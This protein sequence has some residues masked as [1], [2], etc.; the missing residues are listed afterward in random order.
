[1][2]EGDLHTL[3]G[4]A[5]SGDQAARERAFAELLRLLMIF[6]RAG[7]GSA[8]RDHRES[9][10]V[11]QSI[12]R[13]FVEDHALGKVR[14]ASEGEVIAYLK[15]IV[16]SKMA[17][18]A[19]H[20]RAGKR[21]GGAGTPVPVDAATEIPGPAEP[22]VELDERTRESLRRTLGSLGDQ[23]REL[24]RMKLAGLEWAQIAELMEK[25]AVLLRK[26]W[27]RLLTRLRDGLTEPE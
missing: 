20:D 1:M 9:D 19:R 12:A 24:V 14:F 10:D 25:D 17:E 23:E 3:L 11:C 2:A 27:S 7:M 8:I 5:S 21:G 6:V 22:E 4:R 18:L 26:Q 15:T 13:S 16:R